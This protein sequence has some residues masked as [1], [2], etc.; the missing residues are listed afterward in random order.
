MKPT[1]AEARNIAGALAGPA[2][3]NPSADGLG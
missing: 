3:V 2:T 1:D